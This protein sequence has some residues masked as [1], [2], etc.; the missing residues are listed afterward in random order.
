MIHPW[1][2]SVKLWV[3]TCCPVTFLFCFVD[4]ITALRYIWKRLKLIRVDKKYN[5]VPFW[6]VCGA[7]NTSSFLVFSWLATWYRPPYRRVLFYVAYSLP[8]PHSYFFTRRWISLHAITI[9][10]KLHNLNIWRFVFFRGDLFP[11]P[12]CCLWTLCYIYSL[13][14]IGA[15]QCFLCK[16][17]HRSGDPEKYVFSW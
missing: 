4:Y 17:K 14:D 3:Q 15:G 2:K 13:A 1:P 11:W 16:T 5:F 12:F 8:S 9:L 6:I 7:F 10:C